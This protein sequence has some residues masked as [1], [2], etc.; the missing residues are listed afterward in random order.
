MTNFTIAGEAFSVGLKL[1]KEL[2]FK[3]W[4]TLVAQLAM[5]AKASMWWWGDALAYGERKYG[6]MYQQALK[7]SRYDYQTLADAK[8]VASRFQ[9]S[10]RRENLPWSHH[11]EVASLEPKQQDRMLDQAE[12]EKLTRDDLRRAVR[13]FVRRAAADARLSESVLDP[14]GCGN[15]VGPYRC[16]TCVCGDAEDLLLALPPRSAGALISDP[17]YGLD[18]ESWD[19]KVPYHLLAKFLQVTDGPILWFGAAPA[20]SEAYRSFDPEPDRMLIW[21]PSFTMSHLMANGLQFRYHP[22]YAWRLPA[23]HD[24]PVWDVLNTRTEC[25]G[26]WWWHPCTKPLA[27]MQ[28]LCGI[29]PPGAVILDPFAGSGSTLV[30]ARNR[31][32]HFLGFEINAE[33]CAVIAHRLA[34]Q[35]VSEPEAA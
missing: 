4:E 10:R 31:G 24:G 16:C 6:V 27:L 30:A 5:I 9:F 22:I 17:P 21:A 20:I 34:E 19:G 28:E 25:G 14:E 7:R 35:R 26:S 32:Q 8:W 12:T 15:H 11:R 13:E 1:P 23:S 29:A 3:Q 2:S 33:Y 18:A